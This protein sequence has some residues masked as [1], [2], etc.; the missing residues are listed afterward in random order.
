MARESRPWYRS[1]DGWWMTCIGGKQVKL[2]H[3]PKNQQTKKEATERLGELLVLEHI[4]GKS[5]DRLTVAG[6]IGRY[7][8]HA[9]HV[10]AP[11][12]YYVRRRLL[13]QFAEAHGW[14]LVNDRDCLPVHLEERMDEQRDRWK[15]DWTVGAVVNTVQRPFN[16]A[17]KKH[18]LPPP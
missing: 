5:D 14:R 7:L 18:T 6:V 13:Q 10:N 8:D 3:G 11:R 1:E 2:I 17:A 15:S 16:W 9:K 4:R 12:S